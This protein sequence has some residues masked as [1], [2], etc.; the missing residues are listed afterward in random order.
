MKVNLTP[1]SAFLTVT[2]RHRTTRVGRGTNDGH[3]SGVVNSCVRQYNL[4]ALFLFSFNTKWKY[5]K[6]INSILPNKS[7]H[8]LWPFFGQNCFFIVFL[9]HYR[10]RL[11]MVESLFSSLTQSNIFT[12]LWLTRF[13][14]V[15]S[16]I[17]W[18]PL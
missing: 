16:R 7:T 12:D 2:S 6:I 18:A 4:L 1:A 3:S 5:K 15:N 11:R 14:D 8:R 10:W 17:G 9:V 13:L